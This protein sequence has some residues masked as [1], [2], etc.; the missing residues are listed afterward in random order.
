MWKIN[1]GWLIKGDNQSHMDLILKKI[2]ALYK[3]KEVTQGGR[4]GIY[5]DSDVKVTI[6]DALG[7]ICVFFFFMIVT[8][9]FDAKD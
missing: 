7:E 4:G 5:Y 1:N 9:F 3:S 8:S 2:F 6:K